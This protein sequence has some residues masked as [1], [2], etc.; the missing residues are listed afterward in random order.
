MREPNFPFCCLKHSL[1]AACL[2]AG[3]IFLAWGLYE[4][5]KEQTVLEVVS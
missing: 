1:G 3:V 2:V 5:F 4:T